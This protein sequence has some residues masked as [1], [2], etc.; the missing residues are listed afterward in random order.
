M[1][2]DESDDTRSWS[3]AMAGAIHRERRRTKA[4]ADGL[5]L[6]VANLSAALARDVDV[7]LSRLPRIAADGPK[8]LAEPEGI[9]ALAARI[10]T[11]GEPMAR[12]ES[13][14]DHYS[15]PEPRPALER[16]RIMASMPRSSMDWESQKRRTLAA[17][18]AESASDNPAR[19]DER[20]SIEG[21]IQI[22]DQIVAER[23]REIETLQTALKLRSIT[24]MN[25]VA[26]DMARTEA[27]LQADEIVVHER[28]RLKR[29][30]IALDE[31]RRLSE[32]EL[33]QER[34]KLAR[35]RAEL[36][37]K[38]RAFQEERLRFDKDEAVDETK[39]AGTAKGPR[40]RWLQRL[41]LKDDPERPPEH[42][43]KS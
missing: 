29:E 13:T 30:M 16:D 11:T 36:V 8:S 4:A 27:V 18:E 26:A 28:E 15:Q 23:D 31:A 17:L 19:K 12:S 33:S 43:A 24:D 22:T 25:H 35:E 3:E 14:P 21:M 7:V 20:L 6:S 39:P 10:E 37:E 38:M 40:G 5:R 9:H 32:I 34:A 2:A 42:D 1:T 41:G